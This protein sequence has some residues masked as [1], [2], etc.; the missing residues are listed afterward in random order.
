MTL[1]KSAV[2]SLL[3]VVVASVGVATVLAD[4][5]GFHSQQESI[6]ELSGMTGEELEIGY[7]SRIVPH[8][9]GAT[10]SAQILADK[11][12]HQEL[13]ADTATIIETQRM[14]IDL[15]SGYL[16]DTYD[17]EVEPDPAFVMAPEMMQMLMDAEPAAA[18]I[19]FLFMMREHHESAIQ[20]GEVALQQQGMARELEEQAQMMIDAQ[21][22]EQDRFAMYLAEWYDI[23]APEPTGNMAAAM[24]LAMDFAEDAQ[25]AP[26]TA[27]APASWTG[28][29]LGAIGVLLVVLSAL[30]SIR[31]TSPQRS[32]RTRQPSAV[33]RQSAYQRPPSCYWPAS[34]TGAIARRSARPANQGCTPGRPTGSRSA[35]PSA[36]SRPE[37]APAA[38]AG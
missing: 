34:R 30:I 20:I 9:L 3:A 36:A 16:M 1:V 12:P 25:P 17:M 6:A 5:S 33:W 7:I 31:R 15:L 18:E 23:G 38:R 24:E 14:E 27:M 13:R 8:H 32:R 29:P 2:A 37:F 28:L 10:E 11:A 26:D 21:T 19:M 4:D 35:A 22:E